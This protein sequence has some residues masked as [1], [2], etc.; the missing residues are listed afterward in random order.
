MQGWEYCYVQM[1]AMGYDSQV[2]IYGRDRVERTVSGS[3][4][5]V[6]AELGRQGWEVYAVTPGDTRYHLKR[7]IPDSQ[8]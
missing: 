2:F 3:I 1:S 7:P 4:Y 5:S 8:P 6:V